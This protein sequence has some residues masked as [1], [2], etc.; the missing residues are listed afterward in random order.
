MGKRDVGEINANRMLADARKKRGQAVD[1][2]SRTPKN[3]DRGRDDALRAGQFIR[4]AVRSADSAISEA[5]KYSRGVQDRK[6]RELLQEA[7]DYRASLDTPLV[8]T[9][10]LQRPTDSKQQQ[11]LQETLKQ[12][13]TEIA[14]DQ[15][16]DAM[17]TRLAEYA[18]NQGIAGVIS[19][20]H[21]VPLPPG[22]ARW[23][24]GAI[25]EGL[26]YLRGKWQVANSGVDPETGV[27][28]SR[29]QCDNC[30]RGRSQYCS[31]RN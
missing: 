7:R 4:D 11:K 22:T 19:T 28:T 18:F 14:A 13:A 16:T 2:L 30:K 21:S 29:W 23:A 12:K 20:L 8:V 24:Q 3:A 6:S 31:K 27:C 26:T 10:T 25:G 1:A 5:E 17:L 15:V 9:E